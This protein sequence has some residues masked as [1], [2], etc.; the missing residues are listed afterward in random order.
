MDQNQGYYPGADNNANAYAP[1]S[2]YEE[3]PEEHIMELIEKEEELEEHASSGS[4]RIN[5]PIQNGKLGGVFQKLKIF[6][7]TF[8]LII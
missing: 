6:L 8:V 2:P 3:I 1:M 4:S 7:G 5:K